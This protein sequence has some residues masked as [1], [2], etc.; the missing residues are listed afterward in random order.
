[1]RDLNEYLGI[2]PEKRTDYI[3]I[4]DLPPSP[5]EI[6]EDYQR[7]RD[8]EHRK[9]YEDMMLEERRKAYE[10]MY[11]EE[12]KKISAYDKLK[13]HVSDD[14]S[15]DYTDDYSRYMK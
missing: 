11:A 1:M 10:E 2:K 3:K 15:S 13:A 12:V 6:E 4:E 8:E 9:M 14:K 7:M 5:E